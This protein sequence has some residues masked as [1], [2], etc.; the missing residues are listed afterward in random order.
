VLML[1][2]RPDM[3]SDAVLLRCVACSRHA[4][5][6][7]HFWQQLPSDLST[8]QS[9]LHLPSARSLTQCCSMSALQLLKTEIAAAS[10]LH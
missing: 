4:A 7:L 6:A 9:R 8:L 5:G 1:L 3:V 10:L 2:D